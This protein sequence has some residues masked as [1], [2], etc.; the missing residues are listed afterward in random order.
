MTIIITTS[1][2]NIISSD[3]EITYRWCSYM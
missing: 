3:S 2:S 1:T